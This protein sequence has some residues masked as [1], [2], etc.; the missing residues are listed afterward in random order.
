MVISESKGRSLGTALN[1]I[2]APT[3]NVCI[4]EIRVEAS[5]V[6]FTVTDDV[7]V[8]FTALPIALE[9]NPHRKLPRGS[10]TP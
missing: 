5:M 2:C 4:Q 9:G 3:G 6:L 7:F 1:E 10:Q 8:V